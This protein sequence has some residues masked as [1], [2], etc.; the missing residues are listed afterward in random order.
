VDHT[1]QTGTGRERE[2]ASVAAVARVFG[3]SGSFTFGGGSATIAA[4][5]REIVETRQWVDCD[6][7]ALCY[8]LSRM[9]PGT[10]LLAFCVA[11]GQ[12]IRGLVGALVALF[13]ASLPCS[14][15]AVGLTAGFA[16][17]GRLPWFQAFLRGVIAA[18]VASL[19]ATAWIL[20]RPYWKPARRVRTAVLFGVALT[21][22][23]V[24][25]LSPLALLAL[26]A[27]AGLC[28]CEEEPA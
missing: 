19:A 20:L 1:V 5:E 27:V 22:T 23:V 8:A 26:A 10:N 17:L 18:A 11:A 13:A 4:L 2:V 6:R 14:I 9:T 24:L 25:D 21:A 12:S 16:D 15:I 3:T 28:W 7:F